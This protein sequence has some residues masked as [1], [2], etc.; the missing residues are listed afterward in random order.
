LAAVY[1]R[2]L[3]HLAEPL[4]EKAKAVQVRDWRDALIVAVLCEAPVRRRNITGV[5]IDGQL[6]RGPLGWELHY[7][8]DETKTHTASEYPLSAGVSAAIDSYIARVRP[9][10][11]GSSGH[12]GLWTSSRRQPLLNNAIN[13]A[14]RRVTERWFGRPLTLHDFRRAAGTLHAIHNSARAHVARDLLGHADLRTTEQHYN[15]ARGREAAATLQEIVRMAR[16][17]VG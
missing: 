1:D 15:L 13:K 7:A 9:R 5:E 6:R 4:P 2:A 11:L 12:A 16:R 10:F 8:E 17:N 14:V 3:N